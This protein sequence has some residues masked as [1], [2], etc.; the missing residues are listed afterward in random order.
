LVAEDADPRVLIRKASV[1]DLDALL[2]IYLSSARFHVS[3]DP[4]N[5]RVPDPAAAAARL[6]RIIEDD[7]RS[8]GYLT[9]VVD[10]RVV[11]S[12]SIALLQPPTDGSMMAAVPTAEV[13]IAVLDDARDAGVGTVL[14]AAAENWAGERGIRVVILDMSVQNTD[15]QR[16][17]ERLG[18]Q[19]SGLFLRKSIG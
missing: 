13:G 19:V 17:Y 11:G 14:M 5:Y 8:S 12:V 7:G 4:D 1:E 3:L 16:F 9:A 15:A 18:Y 10:G 6:R 2:D